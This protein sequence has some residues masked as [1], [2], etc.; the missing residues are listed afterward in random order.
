LD[1]AWLYGGRSGVRFLVGAREYSFLWKFQNNSCTHS[2]WYLICTGVF[3]GLKRPEREVNSSPPSSEDFKN[4]WSY[5]STLPICLRGAYKENFIL[6]CILLRLC[7]PC[8]F[9]LFL[10]CLFSSFSCSFLQFQSVSPFLFVSYLSIFPSL[11]CFF[12]CSIPLVIFLVSPFCFL[13]VAFYERSFNLTNSQSVIILSGK[14]HAHNLLH[15]LLRVAP[16]SRLEA[17]RRFRGTWLGRVQHLLK[18]QCNSAR[19]HIFTLWYTLM[20]EEAEMLRYECPHELDSSCYD[21]IPCPN[22][23]NYLLRTLL[24]LA[25]CGWPRAC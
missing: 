15:C 4:R 11:S 19:L 25:D 18:R 1:R 6:L 16:S 21:N 7:F 12:C 9:S 2:V 20:T 10:L 23:D 17:Y 22:V 3:P 24:V 13:F 14:K 5:T 8:V